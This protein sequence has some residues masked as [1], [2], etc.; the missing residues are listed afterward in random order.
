MLSRDDNSIRI[1]LVFVPHG[2]NKNLMDNINLEI[3]AIIKQ[4]LK[5]DFD[6]IGWV[7][8][9]QTRKLIYEIN[10][11]IYPGILIIAKIAE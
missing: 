10:K 9:E 11:K 8:P 2:F 1:G 6:A 5:A 3:K 7:F 4:A